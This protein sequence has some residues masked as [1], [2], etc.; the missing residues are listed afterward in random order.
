MSPAVVAPRTR[1]VFSA[2]RQEPMFPLLQKLRSFPKALLQKGAPQKVA[3]SEKELRFTRARQANLFWLVGLACLVFA[4]G[5]AAASTT[6]F[7]PPSGHRVVEN[8]WWALPPLAIGLAL[9]W[10]AIHLTRHAYIILTPI[11]IEIFPLLFP[12]KNLN[13][14]YWPQV[15]AIGFDD[16]HTQM[17]IGLAGD[18]KIFLAL[19]PIRRDRIELLVMATEGRMAEKADPA[20]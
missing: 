5:V 6:M 11:G 18:S 7:S 4:G 14:V 16:G 9:L 3:A 8:G 10:A 13:V 1:V 15:E 2:H 12:S 20:G 19:A 17:V